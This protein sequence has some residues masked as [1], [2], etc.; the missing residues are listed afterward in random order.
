VP[1]NLGPGRQIVSQDSPSGVSRIGGQAGTQAPDP[2]PAPSP[3]RG[4]R[5]G[6][7]IHSL[8]AESALPRCSSFLPAPDAP[9]RRICARSDS[10][11]ELSYLH[12]PCAGRLFDRADLGS[13][14]LG[15]DEELERI[16]LLVLLHEAASLLKA[17]P[18]ARISAGCQPLGGCRTCTRHSHQR[19]ACS[20]APAVRRSARTPGRGTARPT[21]TNRAGAAG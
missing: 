15:V 2:T 11:E 19:T 20:P 9:I 1:E 5:A 4:S 16:E 8:P 17:D 14:E 3:N 12:R 6:S 18:P 21:R 13:G 10:V 7:T